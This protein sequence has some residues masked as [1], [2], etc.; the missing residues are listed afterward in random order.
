M[1]GRRWRVKKQIWKRGQGLL[2]IRRVAEAFVLPPCGCHT[3]WN[4]KGG[5]GRAA[6][7]NIWLNQGGTAQQQKAEP[8][9]C[10][11]LATSLYSHHMK[12]A[13]TLRPQ[14]HTLICLKSQH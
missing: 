7:K 6:V 8:P 13:T 1:E 5:K 4:G 2:T 10:T 9:G 14:E 11:T 3:I 12:D